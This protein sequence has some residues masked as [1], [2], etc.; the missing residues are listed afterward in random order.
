VTSPAVARLIEAVRGL[1]TFHAEGKGGRRIGIGCDPKEF[2]D[3]IADIH[4]ALEAFDGETEAG[5]VSDDGAKLLEG[6]DALIRWASMR[7]LDADEMKVVVL[8][9]VSSGEEGGSSRERSVTPKFSVGGLRKKGFWQVDSKADKARKKRAAGM[10]EI[11]GILRNQ[12]RNMLSKV[13]HSEPDDEVS[14]GM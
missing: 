7:G 12:R 5:I 6:I 8:R 10:M 2:P 9:A 3:R 4:D 11:E 1:A 14:H 13:K